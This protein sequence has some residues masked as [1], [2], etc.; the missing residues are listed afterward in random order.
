MRDAPAAKFLFICAAAAC[1]CPVVVAGAQSAPT[2]V[3][4]SADLQAHVKSDRFQVVTSVRG[5]PLGVRDAMRMLW[6]SQTVDIADPDGEFRAG[7]ATTTGASTR[8]MAVAGCS[9]DHC[10]VY[11]ERGGRNAT[12]RLALFHWTPSA[13]KLEWG[14]VAPAGLKTLDDVRNIV[15][16]GNIQDPGGSW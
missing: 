4:M 7:E 3:R 13:T 8:R 2:S 16:K 11:Y 12:W 15:V 1:L 5:L 9:N 10:L 14:G 6:G